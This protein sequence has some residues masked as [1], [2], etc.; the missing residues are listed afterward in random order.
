MRKEPTPGKQA[1]GV[2]S[3]EA[4]AQEGVEY[5]N[6][7]RNEFIQQDSQHSHYPSTL[8]EKE[9]IQNLLQS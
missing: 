9:D 5:D 8:A 1:P 7:R 4:Q 3:K 6:N 2:L